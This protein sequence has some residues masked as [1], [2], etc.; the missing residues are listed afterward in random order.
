MHRYGFIGCGKMATALVRGGIAAGAFCAEEVAA[1]DA[2]P[3]AA[4]RLRSETGVAILPDNGAVCAM[5][6]ALV[7]C[8]KP[9]DAREALAGMAE[10]IEGKLVISIVAGLSLESLAK[11][12][13]PRARI[14]RVMPNMPALIQK[15]ASAYARGAS[16]TDADAE[17]V[18]GLFGAAGTVSCVPEKLL[19]AVTG[20]SGSGPAYIYLA[21]EALA[22]GGVLMG[23]P[24]DLAL[25]LAAQT[26]AG[27]AE[28]VLHTGEHPAVLRDMV[29]SPGGTT[30]AGLEV[31]ESRGVRGAFMAAVRAASARAKELG[32]HG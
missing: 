15:G 2:S 8:V 32:A 26:V 10:A 21:I 28:M 6:T 25:Q 19:N 30:A 24:R 13:G 31:L 18:E 7:L 4:Q 17:V 1:S 3:A 23:L 27:A 22:D 12:A 20:L 29:T 9:A 14:V 16:A 5:S 11:A